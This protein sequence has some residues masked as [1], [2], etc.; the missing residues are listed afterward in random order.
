MKAAV[1]QKSVLKRSNEIKSS[2][3]NPETKKFKLDSA[4]KS[5][6]GS[7]VR[8]IDKARSA[9]SAVSSLNSASTTEVATAA[10]LP[11]GFFDDP[12]LDAKVRGVD[13]AKSLDA[14]YEEFKKLMQ[15]EEAKSDQIVER[16]DVNR[17]IDRE[18]AEVDELIHRWSKIED[19]HK[20]REELLQLKKKTKEVKSSVEEDKD[21]E[22]DSEGDQD[23]ENMLNLDIRV[24]KRC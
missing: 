19:M 18:L 11:E 10:G 21:S 6:L 22:S 4:E 3:E 13:K 23:L 2:S 12:D 14:E 24:K 5:S 15:T 7:K 16:D 17:D 1:E 8:D 20:K 9:G